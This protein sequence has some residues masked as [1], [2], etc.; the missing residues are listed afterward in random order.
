MAYTNDTTPGV[1]AYSKRADVEPDTESDHSTDAWISVI[2]ATMA[3]YLTLREMLPLVNEGVT[4]RIN[5]TLNWASLQILHRPAQS[6]DSIRMLTK[7][8]SFNLALLPPSVEVDGVRT[9]LTS[10]LNQGPT[11]PTTHVEVNHYSAFNE[12]LAPKQQDPVP[13][14]HTV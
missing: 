9:Y 11:V 4:Q 3:A 5:L 12:E 8:G 7:I 2:E 13:E 14:N 6:T 1:P 10:W